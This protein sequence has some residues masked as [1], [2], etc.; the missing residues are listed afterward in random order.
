MIGWRTI[1]DRLFEDSQNSLG[2]TCATTQCDSTQIDEEDSLVL[3]DVKGTSEA[4]VASPAT[5][6]EDVTTTASEDEEDD[7]V[8]QP[9]A[10]GPPAEP[11]ANVLLQLSPLACAAQ[12]T[13]EKACPSL[14][15]VETALRKKVGLKPLQATHPASPRNFARQAEAVSY[16]QAL[17]AR[18][19]YRAY[20]L[21][22][23]SRE[24]TSTGCRQ[25]V[26]DSH[27]GF[28]LS[29]A[30]REFCAL[31]RRHLYEV[32]MDERPCWLYFDLEYSRCANPNLQPDDVIQAFCKLF[33]QFCLATFGSPL[34][35]SSV[36][37]LDST[38]P[39]KF[40]KHVVAKRLQ[41]QGQS[42]WLAFRNNAEV[43]YVVKEF[44]K[45][46]RD[47]RQQDNSLAHFLF[48]HPKPKTGA[49]G[50][51]ELAEA[52]AS[53][54]D[55]VVYTRNRCFRVLFS[56]K[57]GKQRPLMPT[58]AGFRDAEDGLQSPH[59]QLL[60]S[61]ASFVPD[62]IVLFQHPRLPE[63]LKHGLRLRRALKEGRV[64]STDDDVPPE[65]ES[66]TGGG[67]G[68]LMDYLVS[69][70]DNVRAE[71]EKF[72]GTAGGKTTRVQRRFLMRSGHFLVV[73]LAHNNFC[74]HKGA[75]HKSNGIYLV[76]DNH[77]GV[78]YQKCHDVADCPDFRSTEFELPETLRLDQA[79]AAF[80]EDREEPMAT[81]PSK[82]SREASDGPSL[83][84]PSN[85]KG[86]AEASK[87][88]RPEQPTT[89][90]R[91]N[92]KFC[93]PSAPSCGN[94][95]SDMEPTGA[96]DSL[97]PGSC[98]FPRTKRARQ[99]GALRNEKH[100]SE[101]HM[102]PYRSLGSFL[103]DLQEDP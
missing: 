72:A 3:V 49:A 94:A 6:D 30:P 1:L 14:S 25:F 87:R 66:S 84:P 83:T 51:N 61:L 93:E 24:F 102:H 47:Q 10:P 78:F 43:G 58:W 17:V 97:D 50:G 101:S 19:E 46:S 91:W 37:D 23:F 62:C 44:V 67:G 54:V 90:P 28:A 71:H 88:K 92:R 86:V 53:V 7:K 15:E 27:A 34:D 52:E 75:S 29:S 20:Q 4:A 65:W 79:R 36:Y 64:S 80:K 103:L 13:S 57:F 32:I 81:P 35:M 9:M 59:L 63:E 73:S 5:T 2:D 95:A 48:A 68:L 69:F 85:K 39:E 70:W 11:D 76:V 45:F 56:S 41:C 42:E 74:L 38:S 55:E 16:F 100:D 77:R 31:H 12:P 22:L 60:N 26:V 99:L 89:R 18:G 96:E 40:S 21:G 33:S 98:P 82:K 8:Q